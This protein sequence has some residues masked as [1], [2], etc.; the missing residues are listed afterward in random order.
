[1]DTP[2]LLASLDP[3]S[4]TAE[5]TPLVIWDIGF[6]SD[7]E[8]IVQYMYRGGP[9][10]PQASARRTTP[11]VND[12]RPDRKYWD[13]VKVEMQVFLCTND[14]KYTALWKQ[15]KSSASQSTTVI[16]GIIATFLGESIGAAGTLLTGFVAVCLFAAIK[17]GKEAYCNYAS[18]GA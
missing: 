18:G 12:P 1:M 2:A 6:T 10:P 5:A 4:L 8:K 9:Y 17:L 14:K 7:P 11:P 13:Y 16:V 15:L 3:I